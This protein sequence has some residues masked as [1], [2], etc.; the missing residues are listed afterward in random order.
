MA[1][2]VLKASALGF[3]LFRPIA[4]GRQENYSATLVNGG[5]STPTLQVR[6]T[7]NEVV[8]TVTYPNGGPSV[9]ADGIGHAAKL[10]STTPWAILAS[11]NGT[12]FRL[13]RSEGSF[14]NRMLRWEFYKSAS[15]ISKTV[16]VAPVDVATFADAT[17]PISITTL[18]TTAAG[19]SS[20]WIAAGLGIDFL[21]VPAL[22]EFAGV[23]IATVLGWI[24]TASSTSWRATT[25]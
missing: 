2:F 17:P 1:E 6:L 22:A 13:D 8:L 19:E 24:G 25:G 7:G 9:R 4:Q 20:P 12:N 3:G 16:S 18:E 5:T 14:D 23:S 10:M 11:A 21:D 15:P